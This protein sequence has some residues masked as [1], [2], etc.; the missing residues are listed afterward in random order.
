MIETSW[1]RAF[2]A[3]ADDT[4]MSRAARRL[5]LSQ[6]AVHAQLRK[7]SEAL[8]VTLYRRA[9]RGLVLTGEGV[10]VAAFARELDDRSRE[11]VARLGGTS[12]RG[13][14]VLAAGA[15]ALLYVIGEGLR[16]FRRRK[17]APLRVLT[18]DAVAAVD[19]VRSGVAHVGVGVVDGA[20]EGLEVHAVTDV[21]QAVVLPRDHRLARKRRVTLA[22]LAGEALVVPPDGQP[23]RAMLDAALRSRG[24]AVEIGSVARGWELT[25]K[26]VDL[27]FGIAAINA[28]C[29]VPRRLVLRPLPELPR[30]RY[31]AFTRS[32]PR[33]DAQ[34]LVRNL[35]VKGDAWRE[36]SR[37]G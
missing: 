12:E 9:G 24:V 28:C 6:P 36:R 31:A 11:L 33:I 2:A 14:L 1:L 4:N 20:L 16:A 23:H 34:E 21:E 35:V 13:P 19:A 22:D 15:G 3:F 32:R 8:G 25:I 30:V 17:P 18:T 37:G 26:L 10:E 29:Y 5:H 27:G 7:L